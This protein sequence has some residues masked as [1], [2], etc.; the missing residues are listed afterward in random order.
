MYTK[1]CYKRG[2]YTKKV[3]QDYCVLDLETTGLSPQDDMII[4]VGILKIRNGEIVDKY[5]QLINPQREI[6]YFITKLTGITNQM[7]MYMPPIYA[8]KYEVLDFIGNDIIIGHNTAFDLSFIAHKFD[9]D[10]ENEYMDTVQFSRKIYPKMK[11]HRLTDMVE[12]LHLSNNEHR[13]I[14]DC[15]ATHE[16]YE[17]LKNEII[18]KNI[19]L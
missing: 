8:I 1:Q 6:S 11:H 5:V 15:I 7:V 10:I 9:I 17:H 2:Q 13:A 3:I 4:E 19:K 18:E 16:L 14:A 12:F